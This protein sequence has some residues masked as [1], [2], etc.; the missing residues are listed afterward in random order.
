MAKLLRWITTVLALGMAPIYGG[1]APLQYESPHIRPIAAVGDVILVVNT[2]DN[3]LSVFDWNAGDPIL[4]R[5]VR[6]GLEPISVAVLNE[7]QAWVVNHLSD[8]ISVVDFVQGTVLATAQVGDEPAHVVFVKDP[9]GGVDE[10]LAA[11]T[12]SQEDRV[13]FHRTEHPFDLVGSADIRGADPRAMVVDPDTTGVWVV[14][15]ESGNETTLVRRLWVADGPWGGLPP[16]DPPLDP[17]LPPVP[18]NSLIVREMNGIWVDEQGGDWTSVITW[19]LLNV[20]LVHIDA[21]GPVPTVDQEIGGV[22]TLLYDLALDPRSG[23][24]WVVNTEARNEILFEPKLRGIGVENNITHVSSD[25]WTPTVHSLNFPPGFY[26]RSESRFPHP[27]SDFRQQADGVLAIPNEVLFSEISGTPELYVTAIGGDHIAVVDPSTGVVS[28]RMAVAEG[29]SGIVESPDGASLLIVN[30]LQN[31]LH[32][33]DPMTGGSGV[34]RPIGASGFDPTPPNFK[35]GRRFLYTGVHSEHG[36]F[37]CASCHPHGHLD[38][39][40]WDLGDPTGQLEQ[41]PPEQNGGVE[42]PPFHPVKG[43]MATQSLRGLLDVGPLHW[44][45]DKTDFTRF[46]PAFESLLGG[47]TLSTSDML[48]FQD[49]IMAVRYPPNPWRDHLNAPPATMPNGSDPSLGELIFI[50]PLEG[51]CAPCHTLPLGTSGIVFPSDHEFNGDQPLKVPQLRGLYEKLGFRSFTTQDNTRGFGFFH[52]GFDP[53]LWDFL[54]HQEE[55]L[56]PERV[57]HVEAFILT[58]PSET[59]GG[60]GRQV[61][62]DTTI[63]EDPDRQQ[64]LEDLLESVESAGV[65]LIVHGS[66]GEGERGWLWIGSSDGGQYQSDRVGELWSH[67]ELYDAAVAGTAILTFTAVPLGQGLR[68]GIDRDEDG[69]Y[70]RTELD[71]GSDP[72][73]PESQPPS[74]IG[75]SDPTAIAAVTRI[76]SVFPNPIGPRTRVEFYLGAPTEVTLTVYDTGGRLVRRLASEHFDSGKHTVPWDGTGDGGTAVA[77]GV[78]LIQLRTPYARHA[79]K[80]MRL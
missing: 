24:L 68:M 75:Q 51:N 67:G 66:T 72:A 21:S 70:D 32:V 9:L 4:L 2:P 33:V 27:G 39:L 58:F 30:R 40:S 46:N 62:I 20:D 34:V 15:F 7:S 42:I 76:T 74:G 48:D 36:S 38:G 17:D 31:T 55:R 19:D 41:L 78:Y 43:P 25:D 56:D 77:A 61:T 71:A 54:E 52:D 23:D 22:G 60:V 45:G 47:D 80:S 59:H 44:R 57:P 50:N 28:R 26:S 8:D 12:L 63:P 10:L 53:D 29:L 13:A 79:L 18:W 14:A 3:R 73:D 1:A 11:V 5:E 49:F 65:D 35:N 6:V 69:Y 64:R 37:A 16:F